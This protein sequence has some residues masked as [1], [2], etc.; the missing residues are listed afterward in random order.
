MI[1]EQLSYPSLRPA[2]AICRKTVYRSSQ[3]F[4]LSNTAYYQAWPLCFTIMANEKLEAASKKMYQ[5]IDAA[6]LQVL[7]LQLKNTYQN[8]DIDEALEHVNRLNEL[9]KEELHQYWY[10]YFRENSIHQIKT[11]LSQSDKDDLNQLATLHVENSLR[12]INSAF[13]IRLNSTA[14]ALNRGY[15]KTVNKYLA[16]VQEQLNQLNGCL[17]QNIHSQ[18]G[19]LI[20]WANQPTEWRQSHLSK[21]TAQLEQLNTFKK[22]TLMFK[23]KTTNVYSALVQHDLDNK[24]KPIQT[25]L[26]NELA[27]I[28]KPIKQANNEW[29]YHMG[30]VWEDMLSDLE[31]MHQSYL[32]RITRGDNVFEIGT[33]DESL[34]LLNDSQ[35]VSI[36]EI[37]SL[38]GEGYDPEKLSKY[39]IFQFVDKNNYLHDFSAHT[40]LEWKDE[41]IETK[42]K[43]IQTLESAIKQ[44]K[45]EYFKANSTVDLKALVHYCTYVDQLM[46]AFKRRLLSEEVM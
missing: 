34:T 38:F 22:L 18:F 6:K 44:Q 24:L 1:S 11:H 46:E 42:S 25:W 29:A 17:K 8:S 5:Q 43:V 14:N 41:P 7:A 19:D 9:S 40:K 27:Q 39:S 10:G 2:K 28:Q 36:P 23:Y 16:P 26:T 35:Y 31:M 21:Y 20:R 33:E 32:S 4:G 3:T 13:A 45:D 15:T 12:D 37:N 30:T